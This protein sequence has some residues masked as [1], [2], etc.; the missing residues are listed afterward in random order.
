ME[1]LVIGQP[2]AALHFERRKSRGNSGGEE[3][4]AAMPS[5]ELQ[6][7]NLRAL[8]RV[9]WRLDTMSVLVGPNGSGKSTLLLVLKMLRA[10]LDRG[11]PEAVTA[12]FGGSSS[13]RSWSSD[14]A[15]PIRVGLTL[16]ELHWEVQLVPAGGTVSDRAPERLTRA[17]Q[18]IF[19]KDGAGTISW[20]G[21]SFPSL[22]R[23]GLELLLDRA[24]SEPA[25]GEVAQF[26]RGLT[27]F[28]DPDLFAIRG[29][30]KTTQN[31]HLH[32]RGLNVVTMLR[33][34]LQEKEHRH[35]YEFVL[36]GLKAAV[37][38]AVSDLEFLEAGQ[39]L[40]ARVFRP[41]QVELPSPL[42]NEANGVLALVVLFAELAAA[43]R[44]G[45]VAIDE[46]ENSLHPSAIRR[47]LEIAQEWARQNELS[48]ILTT[49]S[50]VV[51]NVFNGQPEHVF[52]MQS[53]HA[54]HPTQPVRLD[55]LKDRDWL[56]RFSFGELQ[57]QDELGS[58]S[59]RNR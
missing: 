5:F 51:L 17:G 31:Q 25:V 16:G 41:G 21:Q 48:I 23:L 29:G 12:V 40:V 47:F 50:P 13:L 32:S 38:E 36:N 46:P 53:P 2:R 28:H 4:N 49:H 43:Q 14:D 6:V 19:R 59:S 20:R 22:D 45:V 55:R 30:S 57:E 10:A 3:T 9:R 1:C 24:V 15:S 56:S 18:E 39:T 8:T 42:E 37:P 27:V 34:W 26:L 35:R 7:D 54:E 52:V 44:G 33:R 58:N 11:L